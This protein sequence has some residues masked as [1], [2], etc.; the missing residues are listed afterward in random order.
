[1]KLSNALI[2]LVLLAFGLAYYWAYERP[3][4]QANELSS[5]PVQVLE[6]DKINLV[7]FQRKDEYFAIKK[8]D[9]PDRLGN[10][11]VLMDPPG[12]PTDAKAVEKLLLAAN[13]LK[14]SARIPAAD[15]KDD[16]QNYGLNPPELTVILSSGKSEKKL[17]FG[18]LNFISGRRYME[19]S[20][21]DNLYLID[22][23][24][25][26]AFDLLPGAIRQT[27]PYVL[28]K[29]EVKE[30]IVTP[31]GRP[32]TQF[33]KEATGNWKFYSPQGEV[34]ADASVVEDA[35]RAL[36]SFQVEKFM[37]IAMEKKA[38][39]NLE[40]ADF[41]IEFRFTDA[42]Q[43]A[44]RFLFG[45]V[46]RPKVLEKM[47]NKEKLDLSKIEYETDYY[48]KLESEPWV[49]KMSSPLQQ[50]FTKE[51]REYL[52]HK[53]FADLDPT[54]LGRLDVVSPQG[55]LNFKLDSAGIWSVADA[56]KKVNSQAINYFLDQLKTLQVMFYLP[57]DMKEK[58][59]TPA[60]TIECAQKGG[61][62]YWR[63]VIGGQVQK[64]EGNVSPQDIPPYYVFVHSPKTGDVYGIVDALQLGTLVRENS[65]FFNK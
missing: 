50:A 54:Q 40:P 27:T 51:A 10:H 29:A 31:F 65:Y 64:Q 22:G 55:A 9:K 2:M 38:V 1:M 8:A 63:L 61:A 13:S 19:I 5:G 36:G 6:A 46:K 3:I 39:F 58:I 57:T 16:M 28:P 47:E 48:T 33:V 21:D 41:A 59:E 15:K 35:I 30:V 52:L 18:A 37:D 62:E 20:G 45:A 42:K 4:N 56:D 24:T 14:I 43:S 12:A 7:S 32:A 17:N 60:F 26:R 25:H 23:L 34:I 49:Y 11:W 44:L 53:A